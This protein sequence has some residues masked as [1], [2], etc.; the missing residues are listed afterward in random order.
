MKSLLCLLQAVPRLVCVTVFLS[1]PLC[2]GDPLTPTSG[3]QTAA[4]A[5][6]PRITR[7]FSA[8]WRFVKGD[9]SDLRA[10]L[11][12]AAARPY[13]VGMG[14]DLV[15]VPSACQE[16]PKAGFGA[17]VS[18]AAPA[19]NDETWRALDLPHDWGV[20]GPFSYDLPG[21]TG[22]LPWAGVGWYRKT[23][24]LQ[25]TDPARRTFLQFDGAMS[26]ALVWCNGEFVGGWPYGYASWQVELTGHLNAGRNVIAV[27]L[28]NP[29]ESSRWYPGGGIYR[30]VWL[31]EAGAIHVDQWGVQ[32]VTQA[33]TREEAVVD[34][35]VTLRNSTRD[36]GKPNAGVAAWDERQVEPKVTVINS[37]H[38]LDTNGNI[39]GEPLAISQPVVTPVQDHN[40]ARINTALVLKNPGL[41]C[42]NDPCRHVVETLVFREGVCIDRV[43]TTFGLRTAEFRVD[44]FYLNGAKVA[45][46]GVCMHHDLGALGAAAFPRAIERQV[47]ILK[48][49]GC[50][51]IRTSHNPPSPVLL[52][53]CDRLGVLVMDEAFD[54]W[55]VAKKPNGYNIDFDDWHEKDMRALVRRD[56]NHPSVVL[57]S[58][59]NE[60]PEQVYPQAWK[61]AQRLSSICREEDGTRPTTSAFNSVSAQFSGMQHAVDVTGFNYKP[62]LYAKFRELNPLLPLVGAE[63]ASTI[64]SRGEYY[65]PVSDDKLQGRANFHVSSYD[66]SAPEWAFSP[67]VE[68]RGLDENKDVAGEFVWTGFDYLGEPTPYNSDTTNILNFSDSA[69]REEMRKQLEKLGNLQVPSRSSYF[70]IIDLAGFPKDRFYLYQARWKP[71]FPMAHILPHWN[72][73][74]RVGLVTPVHVYSSG[75]EAELFLNG[76]TLGVRKRKALEYRFRWDDVVYAPG[77][78]RVVVRKQG[79]PWAEATKRTTGS[80]TRLRVMPDRLRLSAD[81]RD[82]CFVKVEVVDERGELV[83]RAHLPLKFKIE[84]PAKIQAVDNG[85]PTSFELFQ[86]DRITSFNGLALV[87][88]RSETG[89]SGRITLSVEAEGVAAARCE[90]ESGT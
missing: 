60:I 35:R 84:G 40:T 81:G 28:D 88:L 66:L 90:I 37:I 41:W 5:S 82:L 30:D 1:S 42:L 46:Q 38:K 83:P 7:L 70:G 59:G 33:L 21:E 79:Q 53:V 52:D 32:V 89:K 17:G 14:S 25:A 3:I 51:A 23:F 55:R 68:W 61:L 71:E 67:D 24:E 16:R 73:P 12:R 22:K 34:V 72:W 86:A 87:V 80:A 47:E 54:C 36:P 62:Y 63:T 9:P 64:S 26:H 29:P 50:N 8:D 48:S 45:L 76:K 43:T 4:P 85:D 77:E 65:F 19:F 18:Y 69:Q 49:M 15:A 44:G 31:V 27:R 2:A 78:L 13:L 58:I 6:S 11:S 57:W 20:E 56:R 10:D 39:V 74:E 75:D